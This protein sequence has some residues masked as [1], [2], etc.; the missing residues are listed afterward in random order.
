MSA[1]TLRALPLP[2]ARPAAERDAVAVRPVRTAPRRAPVQDPLDLV[3]DRDAVVAVAAAAAA[4]RDDFGPVPTRSAD[5]PD[6]DVFGRGVVQVLVEV[7]A[8]LR[9][10]TQLLRWTTTA[11]FEQVRLLTLPPPASPA[12]RTGA[13]RPRRRPVVRSVRVCEP[14]DGVAEVSAVV[15]G[16]VRTQ[17]LAL[18]C[19]GLDGRWR[20]T[21]LETG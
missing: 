6:P 4:R 20:V 15:I 1:S 2:D 16:P 19:E 9:P 11:T 10:C 17:A 14:A 3:L 12:S 7:M 18:R 8:G 21:A 5:L 13:A